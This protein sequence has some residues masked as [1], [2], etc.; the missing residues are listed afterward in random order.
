MHKLTGIQYWAGHLF[1]QCMLFVM[2]P[3]L[4]QPFF[5]YL[6]SW[7][8]RH[9]LISSILSFCLIALLSPEISGA[10]S[11]YYAP[12]IGSPSYSKYFTLPES[13]LRATDN[14][15]RNK[16]VDFIGRRIDVTYRNAIIFLSSN[17][18]STNI[19]PFSVNSSMP[20]CGICT[21]QLQQACQ[22]LDIP[23]PCSI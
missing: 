15:N 13:P 4:S 6:K 14:I 17:Q 12:S 9:L 21:S 3:E 18:L 1:R 19:N 8:K 20:S 23:P 16:R 5:I 7:S 22:L 11:S 2:G 10:I